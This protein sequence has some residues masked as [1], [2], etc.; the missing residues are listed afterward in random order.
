L[1]RRGFL[2]SQVLQHHFDRIGVFVFG[3][4]GVVVQLGGHDAALDA[5][6]AVLFQGVEEEAFDAAWV[7]PTVSVL[8]E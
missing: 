2:F 8:P 5:N 4:R 3:F 7:E 1:R 6:V